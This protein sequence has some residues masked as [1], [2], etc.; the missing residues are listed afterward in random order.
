MTTPL[1]RSWT[2]YSESN[3]DVRSQ[4]R[5]FSGLRR[6]LRCL[7]RERFCQRPAG[8]SRPRVRRGEARQALRLSGR[9]CVDDDP[10]GGNRIV[11]DDNH[12]VGTCGNKRTGEI[13]AIELTSPILEPLVEHRLAAI[14]SRTVMGLVQ[15]AYCPVR[16]QPT[17]FL[18]RLAALARASFGLLDSSSSMDANT[19][20]SRSLSRVTY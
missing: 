20:R 14:E 15:S 3:H 17:C 16:Q 4:V 6:S 5:P 1:R 18:Y 9:Q 8:Q 2:N 19:C 10:M 13:T 7:L 12:F 11:A